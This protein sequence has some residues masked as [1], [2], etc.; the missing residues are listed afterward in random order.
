MPFASKPFI[1]EEAQKKKAL[2]TGA[3]SSTSG[4]SVPGAGASVG[5][6]SSGSYANIQDYLKANEGTATSM[7]AGERMAGDITKSVSGEAEKAKQGIAGISAAAPSVEAY[8]P[9]QT[10]KKIIEPSPSGITTQDKEKYKAMKTTGGYTGPEKVDQV[11][12]YTDAMNQ[13]RNAA[14]RVGLTGTESGQQTLLQDQYARPTYAAGSGQNKLDQ[15]L[16]QGSKQGKASM[17]SLGSKYANLEG[18]FT[19]TSAKT[20]DAINKAIDQSVKNKKAFAGAESKAWQ[21]FLNPIQARA[22]QMNIDNPEYVKRIQEDIKDDVL[23]PETLQAFGLQGGTTLYDTKL[24]DYFTPNL[25]T[26]GVNQAANAKE[27]GKYQELAALFGDPT[28]T[29]IESDYKAA[30]PISF[31][32]DKFAADLESKK[33]AADKWQQSE[34]QFSGFASDSG[35][36]LSFNA[37]TYNTKGARPGS[38]TSEYNKKVQKEK[39]N[40]FAVINS[41]SPVELEGLLKDISSVGYN[42]AK[43]MADVL[44]KKYGSSFG[45]NLE[46][47]FDDPSDDPGNVYTGFID[48]LKNMIPKFIQSGKDK[49]GYDRRIQG[50]KQAPKINEPAKGQIMPGKIFTKA[51]R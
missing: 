41:M 37:P 39:D 44:F 2:S 1:D 33:V 22:D 43:K 7:G 25:S 16:L 32:K 17:Q 45:L 36:P 35:S 24:S 29:E 28:R 27:R 5:P 50:Y 23:T 26:V 4:G 12:G 3:G 48:Q 10:I 49:Y 21:D 31:N 19:E 20:G 38:G 14:A 9:S 6:K 11:A 13:T 42:N 46:K 47:D 51:G 8:D 40:S 30:G 34:G 18:L 15:A